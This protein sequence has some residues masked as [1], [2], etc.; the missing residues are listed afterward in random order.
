MNIYAYLVIYI[1]YKWRI[2][3]KWQPKVE[4]KESC[5]ENRL[6]LDFTKCTIFKDMIL[7][8][9]LHSYKIKIK[10]SIAQTSNPK[11]H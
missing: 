1:F 5:G 11:L 6:K 4:G 10:I 2:S 3:Q 7:E 8:P 9:F